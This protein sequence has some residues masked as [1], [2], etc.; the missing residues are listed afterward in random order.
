MYF[1]SYLL[2]ILK[3]NKK[4][5]IKQK[6]CG[7]LYRNRTSVFPNRHTETCLNFVKWRFL[8]PLY[9][10]FGEEIDL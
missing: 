7:N 1:P 6:Q 2:Y 9:Y 4:H 8:I 3:E 10:D 5:K